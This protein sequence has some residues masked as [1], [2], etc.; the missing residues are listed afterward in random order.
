MSVE[1]EQCPEFVCGHTRCIE[2]RLEQ[3]KLPGDRSAGV[4]SSSFAKILSGDRH[5]PIEN[6]TESTHQLPAAPLNGSDGTENSVL[7][8]NTNLSSATS[9]AMSSNPN[10]DSPSNKC[11]NAEPSSSDQAEYN[12]SLLLFVSK[13]N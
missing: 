6:T 9:Q 4:A 13:I 2:C 10:T 11:M 7:L 3:I 5:P 8:C 1:T 12:P